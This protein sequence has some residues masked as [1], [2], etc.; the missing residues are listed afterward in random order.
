ACYTGPRP[1]TVSTT[2]TPGGTEVSATVTLMAAH[3][4]GAIVNPRVDRGDLMAAQADCNVPSTLAS[5]ATSAT[6]AMPTAVV[7][8]PTVV[9]AWIDFSYSDASGTSRELS[10]VP[11][12][13]TLGPGGT[14]PPT[15]AL[16]SFTLTP[17]T[18]APGG[19]SFMDVTLAHMAPMRGVPVT[20]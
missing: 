7:A 5:T 11:A 16:A 10:S 1:L 17:S 6:Y 19:V 18:V 4:R 3:P 2:S 12:A 20:V 8:S 9:N 14:E 13:I 15:P